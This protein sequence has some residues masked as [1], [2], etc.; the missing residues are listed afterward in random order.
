MNLSDWMRGNLVTQGYCSHEVEQRRMWLGLRF[1]TALCLVL[2]IAALAMQSVAVLSGLVAIGLLAGCTRRHPFDHIWNH[3][4]RHLVGGAP[5][6]PSPARRRHAFK[7][8]TGILLGVTLL[9]AA[10]F[11]SAATAL[12]A[13]LVAACALVTVVNLCLP[14]EALARWEGRSGRGK[15]AAS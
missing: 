6:P 4:A 8:A 7:V 3:A 9:F 12:G 11:A 5:L 1:S 15:V 10:G 2:V 14:S 13:M